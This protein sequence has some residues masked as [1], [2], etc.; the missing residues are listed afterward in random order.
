MQKAVNK[1]NNAQHIGLL[2]TA[3]TKF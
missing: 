2:V 1:E 3:T